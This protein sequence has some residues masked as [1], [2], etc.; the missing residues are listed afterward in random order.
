MAARVSYPEV[1]ALILG[2]LVES[3][4]RHSALLFQ[5]EADVVQQGPTPK[6]A[7]IQY[8]EKALFALHVSVHGLME[9]KGFTVKKCYAPLSLLT[10]HVCETSLPSLARLQSRKSVDLGQEME[11]KGPGGDV[12]QLQW[13]ARGL[14]IRSEDS[15]R[16]WSIKDSPSPMPL[17]CTS[18]KTIKL[19]QSCVGLT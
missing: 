3:G 2:Y 15:I 12:T 8:L 5:H 14:I 6:G 19:F 13:T 4:Y 10:P 18:H 11:L 7:L 1:N 16:I 17:P 9:D